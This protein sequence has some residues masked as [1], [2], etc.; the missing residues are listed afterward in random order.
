M[1]MSGTANTPSPNRVVQSKFGPIIVNPLDSHI[2][3]GILQHGYWGEH[4]IQLIRQLLDLRLQARPQ[5]TFYDVGANVG[6]HTL[7]LARLFG[8][9]I[10]IR[11]FEA[12][13][14]VFNMLCGTL[15]LNG[16]HR[17]KAHR[18]AVSD[19][20]GGQITFS[21]PD[22]RAENNIGGLELLPPA[23]SDNQGMQRSGEIETV[24]TVTIDAFA[25]AV[26]FIK[27]DI[28]G[29]EHLALD[30]AGNALSTHR[31]MLLIEILKTDHG[32]LYESL[33]RHRYR[34]Y[35]KY[36]D[37]VCIPEES[38]VHIGGLDA[39]TPDSAMPP[40]AR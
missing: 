10:R 23:H 39:W 19:R 8:E 12:Q 2:G 29:M 13:T 14:E 27:L 25:E 7:A 4:D 16:L 32:R 21:L 24:E 11:A 3:R 15:A 9:R 17:I 36:P 1:P 33:R 37:V 26:D 40:T 28:E 18:V 34:I 6:T 35:H 5:V 31:P 20:D 22:Y 38:P 30:G